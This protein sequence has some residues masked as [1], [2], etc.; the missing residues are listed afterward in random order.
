[1]TGTGL[2]EVLET[3]YATQ[4]KAHAYR[5]GNFSCNKRSFVGL[6]CITFHP[7]SKCLQS[8]TTTGYETETNQDTSE[9]DQR[10]HQSAS[11]GD[12]GFQDLECAANALDRLLNGDC[13]ETIS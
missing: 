6:R 5:Q 9:G 7:Y 11:H 12:K 10:K 3:I 13:L 1:M 2:A 8:T 4:C